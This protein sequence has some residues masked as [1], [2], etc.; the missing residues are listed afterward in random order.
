MTPPLFVGQPRAVQAMTMTPRSSVGDILWPALVGGEGA[1][2]LGRSFRLE[3][4]QGWSAGELRAH[5]YRPLAALSR[6]A[7]AAVPFYRKRLADTGLTDEQALTP[8][9]WLRIPL[10]TRQDIRQ[11]QADL[12]RGGSPS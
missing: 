8:E 10:L 9:G 5:Q 11:H 4:S 3:Q 12:I 2:G 1:T 6:H 7:R